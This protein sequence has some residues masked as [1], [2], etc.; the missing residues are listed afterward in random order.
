MNKFFYIIFIFILSCSLNSN[1]TFWS[2][3]EKLKTDKKISKILFEDL[4]PNENEFNPKLKVKLPIKNTS[5]NYNF[6]NNGFTTEQIAGEN[7]SKY[8]F[9][10]IE[11][12]SGFE[13]EILVDKENI[14]FFDDK[15]SIIK[16]NKNSK[17]QWKKNYYSKSDKKNNP[18]LFLASENNNLFIADTNANYYLLNKDNGNLK[19]KK[20]HS[21]SF[22]SQIK[23]KDDKI[24]VVDMENTLRCFYKKNGEILW[25]APTELTVVSSQ[26]KQSLV[27]VENLVIFT[28]SIGD[29][30][31]VDSDNGEIIWQTPTQ[32]LG[33]GKHITLRNSEIVSD[34]ET[35]FI[36]N[37]NNEFFALDIKTGIIKWKQQVNSEIRPVVVSNYIVTISN[38]GLLVIINKNDGNILRINNILKNVKKKKRKNYYPVGFVISD[39]K[40]Y[41]T[42]L[43]GRLFIINFSDASF[44]KILKLDKEKLQRPIYF[45][46]EL[47]IAK[48]NSIIRIN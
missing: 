37:N 39:N 32:V 10:K 46:K 13:P 21:S 35:I 43:N 15:G 31:A 17:L 19:W 48:D 45:N 30:T 26:K 23:I 4:K 22:N 6:N 34:G 29:L 16:F 2:K 42:T 38:E 5:I 28:N 27:L 1:S 40:I 12:F 41:L 47:Y 3:S 11:N 18:I 9:S 24:F 14:Y 44:H 25:S 7:F 20:K 8:K 36:S 33:G